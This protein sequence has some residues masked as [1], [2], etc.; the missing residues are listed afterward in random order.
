[1][2]VYLGQQRPEHWLLR[3][4]VK[5]MMYAVVART[6]LPWFHSTCARASWTT[7]CSAVLEYE[8]LIPSA[9]VQVDHHCLSQVP[10]PSNGLQADLSPPRSSNN[11]A[12]L[13]ESRTGLLAV[14]TG[15]S[16]MSR[17]SKCV[18]LYRFSYFYQAS[19]LFT[20]F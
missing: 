6:R 3:A 16:R 17:C 5:T 4:T 2:T 13:E 10:W 9:T 18:V 12:V 11:L 15:R 14:A 19:A 20:P 7:P 8:P 1:M